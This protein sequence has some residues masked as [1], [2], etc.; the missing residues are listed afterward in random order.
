MCFSSHPQENVFYKR[1][2]V[3]WLYLLYPLSAVTVAVSYQATTTTTTKACAAI[4][5]EITA[6]LNELGMKK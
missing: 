5:A 6:S 4:N 2:V 1:E 3:A